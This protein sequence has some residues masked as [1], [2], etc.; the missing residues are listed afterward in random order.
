MRKIQVRGLGRYLVAAMLA[1]S[2]SITAFTGFAA[3]DEGMLLRTVKLDVAAYTEAHD[4]DEKIQTADSA[5]ELITTTKPLLVHMEALRR[6]YHVFGQNDEEREK[7]LEAL[8]A[9]YMEDPDNAEK[10]FDYGYAQLVMEANKN[11]LFFL[12]KANDKLV[13]PYTSLA[14]GLAQ[15]DVD[16]LIEDAQPDALTTRKMDAIYKLKDALVYNK[17]EKLPG[18]WASY[19]HILEG[20]KDYPAF[21]SLRHEDVTTIYV[22]YALPSF[23]AAGG[24]QFLAMATES[25]SDEGMLVSSGSSDEASSDSETQASCPVSTQSVDWSKLA[26]SKTMDL[27]GEGKTY[28]INF[29]STD[30]EA[31]YQVVVM[32]PDNKQVGHFESF[33]APYIAEDV[34]GDGKQELVVRQFSKDPYHPLYV[35]RWNGSCFAQDKTVASYF[36]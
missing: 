33:V 31:P 11:G 23:T 24:D 29:F 25:H 17:D 14:Y 34:D 10:Y 5:Y 7:L 22:P 27:L 13:S 12:R 36:K 35:Y 19:I 16:R 18:I 30:P 20:L 6:A 15:V 3:A 28:S 4:L 32:G 26:Q 8:K 21:D 9:R 2:L 1:G